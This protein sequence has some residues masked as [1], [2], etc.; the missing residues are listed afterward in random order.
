MAASFCVGI[1]PPQEVVSSL[2]VDCTGLPQLAQKETSLTE[3]SPIQPTI[4]KVCVCVDTKKDAWRVCIAFCFSGVV[5][6][7]PVL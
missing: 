1:Y 2:A 4:D 6:P 7:I 5:I 3:V